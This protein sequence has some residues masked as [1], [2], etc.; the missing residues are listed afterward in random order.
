[1]ADV[2]ESYQQLSDYDKVATI[3]MGGTLLSTPEEYSSTHAR[4]NVALGLSP[5]EEQKI[6]NRFQ[7]DNG[8]LEDH[9]KHA[10][11]RTA[12]LRGLEDANIETYAMTVQELL[13]NTELISA[14]HRF[15]EELEDM[16]YATVAVS[17]AP[18][19]VTRPYA[20]ELDMDAVY[21]WK[22]YNFTDS[23]LFDRVWVNPEAPSG[24]H[25]VVEGLKDEGVDVAHFGDGNNDKEAVQ[26][27]DAGKRQWWMANPEK[28]VKWALN[29]AEK[30]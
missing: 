30:L 6:Y 24:K 9:M 2:V 21:R 7:G 16:D 20:D 29:E 26:V 27:A 11:K 13:D 17:S 23:G 10:K 1:M 4:L 14:A 19:A 3:D 8:D 5:D 25:E 18:P 15:T 28:A 12:H 22:D